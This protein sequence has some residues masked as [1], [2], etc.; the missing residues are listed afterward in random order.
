VGFAA[1]VATFWLLV[2]TVHLILTHECLVARTAA[3]I[4]VANPVSAPPTDRH[5][6]SITRRWQHRHDDV[7]DEAYNESSRIGPISKNA[8]VA[9]FNAVRP[10]VEVCYDMYRIPGIA[11]VNV[12]IAKDGRVSSARVTGSFAGTPSGACV[13]RAAKT[14][15]FPRSDGL[16]TPYPFYLR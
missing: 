11:I 8:V 10:M 1:L 5:P 7:S 13:E 6:C 9:G 12:V 2:A 3:Q 4:P 15:R 14:A 16:T